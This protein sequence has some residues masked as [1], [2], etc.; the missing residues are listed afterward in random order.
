MCFEL[1]EGFLYA[2]ILGLDPRSSDVVVDVQIGSRRTKGHPPKRSH[3][4]YGPRVIPRVTA[5]ISDQSVGSGSY[6]CTGADGMMVEM[7]CL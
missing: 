2:V 4:S 7:A 6:S 1:N 5:G 3:A